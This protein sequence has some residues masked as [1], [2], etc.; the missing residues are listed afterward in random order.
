M[1]I[2]ISVLL[3]YSCFLNAFSQEIKQ[4]LHGEITDA[5]THSPLPFASV[6]IFRDSVLINSTATDSSGRFYFAG[7]LIGKYSL[8]ANFIGYFPAILT[9]VQVNSGKETVLEFE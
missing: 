8:R 1:K 2:F 7:L 6:G 5:E 3:T 4:S 9:N